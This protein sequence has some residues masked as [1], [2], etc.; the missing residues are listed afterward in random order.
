MATTRDVASLAVGVGLAFILWYGV[1]LTG[2]LGSFWLRV[3][4]AAAALA[5]Y[6]SV[7]GGADPRGGL[8][9]D[10]TALAKGAVSGVL[11][12]ALFALGFSAFRPLVEHGA[13]A[14]YLLRGDSPILAASALIATSICEE[15]FWRLYV[16]RTL[17][18]RNGRAGLALSTLAYA[19][20]HLPTLNASLVLAALA[21]GLYW[22]LLY[23]R[24][25]S[26]GVVAASHIAWTELV[27]VFLPLG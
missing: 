19:S 11:L 12:Y 17:V 24:T 21:A 15:Y 16:Q 27:F 4:L 7:V 26:F 23:Q 25:G 3:T 5:L 18:T 2:I 1:F 20:I 13:A 14:V 10:M 22:G 9:L 8:K 6:A